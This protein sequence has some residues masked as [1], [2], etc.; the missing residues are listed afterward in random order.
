MDEGETC[1]AWPR[2]ALFGRRQ[3]VTRRDCQCPQLVFD[4]R[5]PP[6]KRVAVLFEVNQRCRPRRNSDTTPIDYLWA[7]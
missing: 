2:D 6:L 3:Y 5:L 1:H 4:P 7:P